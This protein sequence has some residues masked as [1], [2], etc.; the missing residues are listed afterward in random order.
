MSG[1]IGLGGKTNATKTQ[2]YS[3]LSVQTSALN[4]PI[5]LMWGK[6]RLTDNLIWY[7]NFKAHKVKQA[8]GKSGAV[9][10]GKGAQSYT[11]TVAVAMAL[12]EGP[13]QSIDRVWQNQSTTTLSALNLTLFTGTASQTPPSFISTNFPAEAFSYPYT[14]YVFSP[15]YDLGSS[16]SLPQHWFEVVGPLSGTMPGTVDV[17]FA[18]C[19]NDL[20]TNPQYGFSAANISIDVSTFA[21]Y[22]AYVQAQGL[23]G[24]PVL[25]SQEAVNTIID[26]W[27]QLTNS[28]IFE[29]AGDL[30][31]VPLGDVAITANGAT[32]TPIAD[33]R[34]DLTVNDF[35]DPAQPI[36]V[37]LKDPSDCYNRTVFEIENRDNNYATYPCEYKDQTLIDLEGQRDANNTSAHEF[38]SIAIGQLSVTLAGKRAAY[39]RNTYQ[40]KLPYR[41]LLL[42][43]GDIVQI[44]DPN[45]EAITH[46]PVRI[47]SVEE[48]EGEVLS[49]TAEEFTGVVG[50]VNAPAVTAA[51]PADFNRLV[52]PGNVNPPAAFEASSA[53]TGGR[54]ELQIAASGGQFWG[55]SEV[56]ISF[57]NASYVFIG[58]ITSPAPQGVLTAGLASH[59]DPD[60]TNTLSVDMTQSQAQLSAVTHADAD[61]LRTLSLICPQPVSGVIQTSGIEFVS[62]GTV[63]ATGTYTDDLTYLRRGQ[64]GTA[65]GSHSSGDQ[66]TVMDL[67]GAGGTTLSYEVPTQYIGQPLYLKFCS[68]N[69]YGLALQDIS[70]VTA[71]SYSPTGA[72]YGGGA[73]GVPTTPTGLTATPGSGQNT[74][75]WNSNPATD[76]VTEYDLYAAPGPGAAFGSA[77]LIW[78]GLA[79]AFVE[80]GLSSGQQRTYFLIAR[81]AVG[82]SN[83]TTGF[84]CT[85]SVTTKRLQFRGGTSGRKPNNLEV[86]F[87]VAMKSGDK[88]SATLPGSL[89]ECDATGTPTGNWTI[90]L[91]RVVSGTPT[92]IGTGTINAGA[93]T[94]TWTFA[95]DVTFNDGDLFTATAPAADATCSGVAYTIIGSATT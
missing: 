59:V 19:I 39:I 79:S 33:V 2:K 57:D 43:P 49:F 72:G 13:I 65:P 32:Y 92:T 83:H 27:A 68:Y 53:L 20:L 28:W 42:E 93:S 8:G 38:K 73:G 36:K 90:T 88:L 22:K 11:Y 63:T 64:Y 34:Y 24:S 87:S 77:T 4:Q 3:S 21:Q 30:K 67:T 7:N 60:T 31:F 40:F 94:G 14:A 78:H 62:Y 58:T 5:V 91:K 29:S 75:S 16:Q 56:Y 35:A 47:V 81:N 46:L 44:T 6:A 41:F 18:D 70:T 15:K 25:E 52:D 51:T 12:C 10:G 9:G 95:S 80:T 61:A 86:L 76:N 17:N 82:P 23:F 89:L 26:R 84:D 1:L 54:P 48:D 69:I 55:G 74:V 85:A 66:F 71:Y 45:N 50:V 37:V